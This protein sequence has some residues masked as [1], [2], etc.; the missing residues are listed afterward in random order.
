MRRP[1]SSILLL[2][3][4]LLDPIRSDPIRL[5]IEID[6][7]D[8]DRRKVRGPLD[9]VWLAGDVGAH[10]FDAVQG[11]VQTPN[12]FTIFAY[13]YCLSALDRVCHKPE[14]NHRSHSFR[15]IH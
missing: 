1:D 9:V 8:R 13:L 14:A 10:K 15:E 7:Y 6:Q 3:L 11:G 5:G 12:H 2:F 4:K